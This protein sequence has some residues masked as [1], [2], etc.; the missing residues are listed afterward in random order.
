VGEPGVFWGEALFVSNNAMAV[1]IATWVARIGLAGREPWRRGL[2]VVAGIPI[3]A[4]GSTFALGSA[5]LL[6]AAWI[7]CALIAVLLALVVRDTLR[8][9]GASQMGERVDFPDDGGERF[10]QLVALAVLVGYGALLLAKPFL[11]SVWY[12]GDD[13]TYHGPAVARW[14][15]EGAVA[16]PTFNYHAYY[17]F[18]AEILSLWFALPQGDDSLVGLTGLTWSVVAACAMTAIGLA[19]GA[20]RVVALLAAALFLASPSVFAPASTFSAVD[21]A[22]AALV[23]AAVAFALP[24]GD[25]PTARSERRVDAAYAGLLSG[26]ALGCKPSFAPVCLVL[27]VAFVG[28]RG[29]GEAVRERCGSVL[30]F[31]VC[32]LATG[33]GWYLRNAVLTGNPLFPAEVGPF[34]GPLRA[35]TLARSRLATQLFDAVGAAGRWRTVLDQHADWPH[36]SFLAAS[37]GYAAAVLHLLRSGRGRRS[38]TRREHGIALLMAVGFALLV[39]YPFMPFSG[40]NNEPTFTLRVA[41]RFL[42]APFGIGLVLFAAM[43]PRGFLGRCLFAACAAIGIATSVHAIDARGIPPLLG[44]AV[45]VA[46]VFGRRPAGLDIDRIRSA[47]MA[48]LLAAAL[49]GIA[50]V[51]D[52]VGER[53]TAQRFDS[54]VPEPPIGA[55]WRVIDELPAGASLRP[56]LSARAAPRGRRWRAVDPAARTLAPTRWPGRCAAEP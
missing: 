10:I 40:S 53:K 52:A 45:L 30:A 37:I 49:V 8:Q 55:A 5:G 16:L 19:L 47:H 12:S 2:A 29:T 14:F 15:R 27:A 4:I 18:N 43:W 17:P 36:A 9:R 7:S 54:T 50:L 56:K 25:A 38:W 22:G 21:L 3:V 28:R 48:G 26:M 35:D 32:A 13:L 20:G 33:G 39:A 23:L 44:T 31:G 41:R 11:T 51:S 24:G 1:A 34:E 46:L 42:L 6:S